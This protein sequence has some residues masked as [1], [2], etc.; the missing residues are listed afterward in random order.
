MKTLELKEAKARFSSI[1]EDVSS[2]EDNTKKR[3]IGTL[4]KRGSVEFSKDWHISE[5][6]LYNL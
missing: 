3:S 4:E 6:E 1:M 2:G 5:E